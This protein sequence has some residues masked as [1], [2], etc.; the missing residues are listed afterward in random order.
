MRLFALFAVVLINVAT[1]VNATC[2]RG[3]LLKLLTIYTDGLQSKNPT[4]I[5]ISRDVRITDNGAVTSLGQGRVWLTPG[6][7]RLPY[8]HAVVDPVSGAAT[9]QAT[10]TNY[11]ET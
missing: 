4:A 2:D 7:L 5:P 6:T 8:R 11:T 10:V 9:I 3:C 1:A